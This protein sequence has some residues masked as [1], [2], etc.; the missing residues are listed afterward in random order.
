M[1]ICVLLQCQV[2]WALCLW[3][4]D[5]ESVLPQGTPVP[6]RH[7]SP[8]AQ[9]SLCSLWVTPARREAS[10]LCGVS[11]AGLEKAIPD[12]VCSFPPPGAA[13][14]Y[15]LR[16]VPRTSDI[17]LPRYS[18]TQLGPGTFCP[19]AVRHGTWVAELAAL[20]PS[21]LCGQRHCFAST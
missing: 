12:P 2:S 14:S 11:S 20:G 19:V 21:V 3:D 6:G 9:W 18:A 7:L 15:F 13:G 4:C 16:K 17:S 1:C 10:K 8:A 5:P